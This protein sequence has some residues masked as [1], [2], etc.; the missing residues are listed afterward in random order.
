MRV[1]LSDF[2]FHQ[3]LLIVLIDTEQVLRVFV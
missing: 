3:T 1:W 2:L